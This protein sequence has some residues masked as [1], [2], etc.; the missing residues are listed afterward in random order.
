MNF[1]EDKL[2]STFLEEINTVLSK[3]QDLKEIGFITITD[4]EILDEG[5]SINVYFS[6]FSEEEDSQKIEE[7]SQYLNELIPQIRS[8]IRKRVKTRYI[9][10]IFFKYDKTPSKASKIEEIFKKIELEKNDASSNKGNSK[11]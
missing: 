7:I 4:I 8:V 10:N 1:K 11:T 6:C 2:K 9:P 3:R 5:R